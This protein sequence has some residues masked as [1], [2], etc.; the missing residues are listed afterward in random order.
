MKISTVICGGIV[1]VAGIGT[2]VVLACKAA[3]KID[4][5]IYK[6]KLREKFIDATGEA[7]TSFLYKK[8]EP[9]RFE[10]RKF[11]YHQFYNKVKYGSPKEYVFRSHAE[12]EE[13][14]LKM[15]DIIAESNCASIA[16]FYDLVGETS[17]YADG[18]YGWKEGLSDELI[19]STANGWIIDFPEV[20]KL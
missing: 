17:A 8:F 11:E 10:P 7:T 18:M 14:R 4:E 6:G 9:K 16:D 3:V 5:K 13:V 12:A 15:N 20:C 2:G 19:T 1:F